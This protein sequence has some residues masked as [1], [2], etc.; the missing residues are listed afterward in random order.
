MRGQI[1]GRLMSDVTGH[2]QVGDDTEATPVAA[3]DSA[4][5]QKS[6][7]LSYA[8]QDQEKARQIVEGLRM[9]DHGVWFDEGLV[10][11][12]EWWDEILERIRDCDIFIQAV[13][14]SAMKSAACQSER[15]YAAALR[16]KV[17][18]VTLERL[19]GALLPGDL[20]GLQFIDYVDATPASAFRLARSVDGAPLAPA[21]PEP[22][23]EPPRAPLSYLVA[24]GDRVRSQDALSLDDQLAIVGTIRTA[25]GHPEDIEG[26]DDLD[27][28]ERLLREMRARRDAYQRVAEEV[29]Q[30]LAQIAAV[31]QD[32]AEPPVAAAT[33][34][35]R[36]T[37]MPA[38]VAHPP[39]ERYAAPPPPR[40]PA[41]TTTAYAPAPAASATKEPNPH[42]ILAVVSAFIFVLVGIFAIINASR[43]RPA[44]ERGDTAAAA[45]ASGRVVLYFWIS[46]GL[47]ILVAIIAAAS[48]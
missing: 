48:G 42:W 12:Q 20:A 7:F 22:L 36:S 31:R 44:L 15:K 24:L 27:A 8:R 5:R 43:V 46:V 21:L 10:G 9:L 26:D 47:F 28:A 45:K 3:R 16:K 34:P 25:L 40:E 14:G 29:D 33:A 17:I 2:R 35:A 13:S 38:P 18:P 30:A 37:P 39:G 19:P 6:I 11:G 41:V 23:P 4:P 1:G 32:V